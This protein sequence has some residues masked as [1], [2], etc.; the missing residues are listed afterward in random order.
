MASCLFGRSGCSRLKSSISDKIVLCNRTFTAS[1]STG[2]RPFF[3]FID[4]EIDMM[5]L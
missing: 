2:G 3:D 1:V 5:I 4:T